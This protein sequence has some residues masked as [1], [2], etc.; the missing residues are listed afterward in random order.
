MSSVLSSRFHVRALPATRSASLRWNLVRERCL[1]ILLL[2]TLSGFLFFYGIGASELYR[3][4]CLRAIVAAEMLRSGNWIV[5]TLYDEPLLTKPPGMYAAI[6]LVSWPVGG[7]TE[8]TSRLPSALAATASVLLFFWHFGRV[9]GAS[10]GLVAALMLPLSIMWLDKASAAEIDMLQVF[11][12]TAAIIFFLRAMED[13]PAIAAS[14]R[15][16]VATSLF[17]LVA[18]ACVAG[19]VLTKWTAPVFFYASVLPLLW[20]R[21]QLRL[22]WCWRHLLGVALAAGICLTWA[23]LVVMQVG[24]QTLYDTVCREALVRLSPGH[25]P[26]PYSWIETAMHPLCFWLAAL[27]ISLFA[28]P[29]CQRR[30][31]AE[32]DERETLLCQAMHCWIWPSLIF[33]SFVPDHALRNSMPLYPGI[34][35]L[36][37]LVWWKRNETRASYRPGLLAVLIVVWWIKLAYVHVVMPERTVGRQTRSKGERI[38]A[39]MPAYVTLYL[40]RFKDEGLM[41]YYGRKVVRLTGPEQLLSTTEPMYCMLAESE[42]RQWDLRRRPAEVVLQMADAQ[43]DPITLVRVW[44]TRH[45]GDQAWTRLNTMTAPTLVPDGVKILSISELTNAVKGVLEDGFPFVWVA[46]EVSNLTRPSSGHIYLTLKDATSQLRTV[47]WRSAVQRLRYELRDGM[48]VI[49]GGRLSVYPQR[50]EYQLMVDRLEPKGIGE[51]ELAFRQLQEKLSKL[52]YFAAER[53]RPVPAFPRRIALVTSPA[54]AAVRDMLEILGRRWPVAEVVV[55]PVRVQ[56][57][58]ASAEIAAAIGMLNRVHASGWPIEVMIVGRGGGSSEDLWSFNEECVARAIFNSR[59]PVVS[60]VGH[61]VDITIADLVADRRALTPSE[62]AELVAPNRIELL[63]WVGRTQTRLSDLMTARLAQV[64]RRL[65]D[66]AD[67]RIF[68]QPLERLHEQ[69]RRL[70]D[71]SE[72]LTRAGKQRLALAREQ[73]ETKAA[74]LEALS[75]LKVLARGYSLTSTETDGVLVRAPEQ[76]RPGDR[77]VTRLQDGRVVSRVEETSRPAAT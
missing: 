32:L 72:R 62:A 39:H 57:E 28:L 67:R 71:W 35:G 20:W 50:G 65:Q 31:F 26:K 14:P 2:L 27:P 1:P 9:L 7:V 63:E 30:F 43:G 60:A 18:L 64:R 70:D 41:F 37:A 61:E 22:L 21:G 74:R 24:W 42:W 59:I 53:K 8:W 6:A 5:P 16:R 47:I 33:W 52:G 56:G 4:E 48:E 51:L 55:C 13:T 58:G 10:A 76:V 69:E 38:A 44:P 75:P 19:G 34:A 3:T 36:A 15:R 49:A 77:L 54:G 40:F 66:L 46:G 29:A 45:S 73:L 68:R 17:W 23:G 12:V 11:W 25:Y